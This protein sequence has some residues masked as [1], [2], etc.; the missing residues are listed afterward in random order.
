MAGIAAETGT[1]RRIIPRPAT[2]PRRSRL[3]RMPFMALSL[4]ALMAGA[5][6][7]A[8]SLENREMRAQQVATPAGLQS[9]TL[10]AGEF[11]LTGYAR[12]TET[13]APVTI[14]I[15]G[16]GLAWLDRRT[17]SPNPTPTRPIGLELA[18]MD[19]GDNV[20]YLARPCQYSGRID[21]AACPSRYWRGARFAEPVIA[22]YEQALD[23]LRTAH[24]VT[25]FDL[26]GY[27]GGG[28]VAALLAAQRPDVRSLRTVAGNI[29]H[30]AFTRIHEISDM[31]ESLN[32]ADY[33]DGLRHLPQYHFIGGDDAVIP[34]AVFD[35]YRRAGGDTDCVRSLIVRNTGHEDGWA[36][37]WPD[38]LAM[39]PR[40]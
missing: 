23:E 22:A 33:A 11:L 8:Y 10:P 1:V 14:Y 13:G 2:N 27:S 3:W 18:A 34:P 5:G 6:G 15:E 20:I 16:D 25:A 7:C 39:A 9:F 17:P 24:G 4:A 12:I 26:V 36:E 35:S 40:C 19:Y 21:G 38:L 32:P 28:G 31:A 30:R 37:R 29:D